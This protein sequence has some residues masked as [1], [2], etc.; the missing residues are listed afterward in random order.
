MYYTVR[1]GRDNAVANLK[2]LPR[3]VKVK[4]AKVAQSAHSQSSA[5]IIN[6]PVK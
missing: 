6:N 3:G 2:T 4:L 1:S 5:R